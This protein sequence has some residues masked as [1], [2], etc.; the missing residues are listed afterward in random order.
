MQY[1]KYKKL[2]K[3]VN[4]VATDEYKKGELIGLVQANSLEECEGGD[5]PIVPTLP[6]II[7][8]E[9]T[10]ADE[11]VKFGDGTTYTFNGTVQ[12]V[13]GTVVSGTDCQFA[14]PGIYTI[15]TYPS[16]FIASI[17]TQ[18]IEI[19]D[20]GDAID[21]CRV[22]NFNINK[23]KVTRLPY[24]KKLF[25]ELT[26][27]TLGIKVEG[28]TSLWADNKITDVDD[29]IFQNCT[30]VTRIEGLNQVTFDQGVFDW[31]LS[32][33]KY[34]TIFSYLT[35]LQYIGK[36]FITKKVT[37]TLGIFKNNPNL[38]R[39]VH[40]F[41][42]QDI[43]TV[44]EDEFSNNPQLTDVFGLFQL[45]TKLTN[46]PNFN[47]NKNI[48]DF[49]QTFFGCTS[50]TGTTPADASGYR[51]WER[52]GK[53]GYP[54]TIDGAGCFYNCTGLSNYSEIPDNWK[55]NPYDGQT[56]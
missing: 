21:I 30:K 55:N 24:G 15:N 25:S 4:G 3:Y 54:T 23:S 36:L 46:M 32:E 31:N 22:N 18:T 1:K 44:A 42:E 52:A 10:Q 37:S 38:Y 40:T 49:R 28:D 7:K 39:A 5:T 45:C 16:D 56:N 26:K 48:S 50:L 35:T 17:P 19:V 29:N 47:A 14:T 6:T 51:F 53:T 13:G 11:I 41:A 20:W 2:R 8:V 34:K 12:P 27:I 9:T 33:E 43:V